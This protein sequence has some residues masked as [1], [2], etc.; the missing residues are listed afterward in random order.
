MRLVFFFF[1]TV[2]AL[3]GLGL[4]IG[5]SLIENVRYDNRGD[6]N[7]R[8]DRA[9]LGFTFDADGEAFTAAQVSRTETW[10]LEHNA[11]ISRSPH[12][13]VFTQVTGVND[14]IVGR[15]QFVSSFY[16]DPPIIRL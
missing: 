9:T 8:L 13:L 16:I 12:R 15:P 10:A 5:D 1:S 14:N 2:V 7:L 4:A 11:R 6:I 3:R